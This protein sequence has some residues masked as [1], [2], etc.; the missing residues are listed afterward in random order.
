MNIK[1]TQ[2][3]SNTIFLFV[4]LFCFQIAS[5]QI[6]RVPQ[7]NIEDFKGTEADVLLEI[8]N[9]KTLMVEAEKKGIDLTKEKMTMNLAEVF[10]VYA[11]WD[12][13]NIATNTPF[14]D[15]I[16]KF[17]QTTSENLAKNLP[18]FERSE[19]IGLLQEAQTKLSKTIK[20]ELVRTATPIVDWSKIT[21]NSNQ[22]MHNG[23][24]VFLA[25][26]TWQPDTAGSYDL[27]EYFGAL[28][29]FYI[30]PNMVNNE[31]GTIA[32]WVVNDLNS[33]PTGN[34]GTMFIGHAAIPSWLQTKYPD[35]LEG[36]GLYTKYDIGNPGA[37]EVV[38]KLLAG[39]VP[40]MK[41]KNYKGQGYMLTN[42]PHWNLA[43]TWE[44]VQFSEKTKDSLRL[45]LKNKHISIANVNTLWGKNYANFESIDLPDFPMAQTEIGKP[46]WYDVMKFNQDRVTNWFTF[47]NNEV[48][49]HD[50]NAKTH[51]KLIPSMWSGNNRYY[52]LDFEALTSLTG[53]IGNDAGAKNSHRWGA[54]EDWE[55]RYAFDWREMSMPYD[56]FR[57]ISPNKVN[58]NSEG[59]FLQ[60]TSFSDLFLDQNYVRS[61]YWL[62]VLQGMNSI[63]SWFW[64]R[65][66]AGGLQDKSEAIAGSVIQQPRV[67]YEITNTMMDLNT[68]SEHI[69][70]L[71][72]QKQ[73]IRIFYSETSAINKTAH[74]DGLFHLYESMYFDGTP[75]GFATKDIIQK[76]PNSDWDVILVYQTEFVTLD[77]L[78]KLQS[79][80]NNGGTIILDAVSLKKDEYGR[81]HTTALN[82]NNGGTII[83]TSS[84]ENF[85]TKAFDI[86]SSKGKL[87][88][89]TLTETN[90]LNL[91]GCMWRAYTSADGRNII[92]I[93]NIGKGSAQVTL[94]LKGAS[95]GIVCTNLIT[96]ENLTSTIEMAPNST[97]LLEI[98]EIS[99]ADAKFSIK[100]VG[101]TCTNKENG[102]IV[103]ES[104]YTTDY[105]ISFNGTKTTFTD[106][107]TIENI[108]PGTYDLCIK[109]IA[110]NFEQCFKVNIPKAVQI[111][112]KATLNSKNITID[113]LKGTPPFKVTVNNKIVLET[114]A[115]SFAV[116]VNKGELV[117]VTSAITCEGVFIQGSA[118][119]Y[120]NPVLDIVTIY[121][122]T[123]KNE[124]AVELYNLQTQ[125]ILKQVKTVK[126]GQFELNLNNMSSGVY[127]LQINSETPQLLKILKK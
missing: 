78:N 75:I 117:Q 70:A 110:E 92:S 104:N 49:K 79:Y 91:K 7:I 84:S 16:Y 97:L 109:A 88:K 127:M 113:V 101:E 62:A 29:S 50:P 13:K 63:Q 112:A 20:G 11:D 85:K 73:A 87:P 93:V 118:L 53:N 35:I 124:V 1:I 40:L 46:I 83:S 21:Y 3:F 77:E 106:A 71:Q 39:T 114:S 60:T 54:V 61:V 96:G 33:K 72:H 67:A 41:D 122:P 121:V 102:Q 80:L 47:I 65:N 81:P 99:A 22:L 111:S 74:M 123:E 26:Y 5:A 58:Y 126:N 90:G 105:E 100:T 43:G 52:G 98:K 30:A 95:K 14:F 56:F 2:Y 9:L 125:L 10:L 66:E 55:S 25:D 82:T 94:G 108:K 76:Q 12:E 44:V 68:F 116:P 115:N 64:P 120:P 34:F 24:P 36:K 86:I 45:W 23:K 4:V 119:A 107:K 17:H 59:H 103:I 27:T 15:D 89:I 6:V 57:S 48:L 69:A 18:T 42:E 31:N 37:K 32:N 8:D 51:I 19:L 38:S 28:D